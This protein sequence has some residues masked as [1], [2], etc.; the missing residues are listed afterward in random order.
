MFSLCLFVI[1][2]G[3]VPVASVSGFTA[4]CHNTV[5]SSLHTL[6]WVCVCLLYYYY[7]HHHHHHR[8]SRYASVANAIDS[9]SNILNGRSVSVN[10]WLVP[11]TFTTSSSNCLHAGPVVNPTC[12]CVLYIRFCQFYIFCASSKLNYHY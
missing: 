1:I 6:G 2:S 3:L 12:N 11:D 4:F 5:T 9:V 7:Y 8:I 10:D